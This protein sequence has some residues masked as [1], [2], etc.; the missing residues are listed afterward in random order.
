MVNKTLKKLVEINPFYKQVCLDNS[1]GDMGKESDPELWK[2]LT[3]GKAKS[4]VV[5]ETDSEGDVILLISS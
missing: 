4:K 2:L 3:D 1:L 5:E